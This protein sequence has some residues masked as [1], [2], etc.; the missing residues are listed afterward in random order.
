MLQIDPEGVH[1]WTPPSQKRK[2]QPVVLHLKPLTVRQ[3]LALYPTLSSGD[4]SALSDSIWQVLE[5]NVVGWTNVNNS[6]G[7]AVPFATELLDHLPDDIAIGAYEEIMALSTVGVE[8]AGKSSSPRGSRSGSSSSSA[9][10][11][12]V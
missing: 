1:H 4:Q 11:V 5:Q 6:A 10:S 3:R 2:K 12:E 9:A 8:E 7:D